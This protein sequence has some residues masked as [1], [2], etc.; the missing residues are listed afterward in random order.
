MTQFDEPFKK[1]QERNCETKSK[2]LQE[3]Y[4]KA[5]EISHQKARKRSN[6]YFCE[7]PL[8]NPKKLFGCQEILQFRFLYVYVLFLNFIWWDLYFFNCIRRLNKN[9]SYT[10]FYLL[11]L[12]W[13][14]GVYN[15]CSESNPKI[16]DTLLMN[17]TTFS[18]LFFSPIISFGK[19]YI[20]FCVAS[21][22]IGFKYFL[23]IHNFFELLLVFLRV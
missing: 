14:D 16:R 17:F 10:L 18:H 22:W 13:I 20:F 5:L 11:S 15:F 4:W 6:H 2:R 8:S 7:S 21:S 19:N 12:I 1:N 23:F 3:I 9:N